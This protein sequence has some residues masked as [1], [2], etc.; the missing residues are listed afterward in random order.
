[1]PGLTDKSRE[2]LQL[3]ANNE[4]RASETTNP[5]LKRIFL[6]LVSGYRELAEHIDDPAQWRAK[7]MASGSKDG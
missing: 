7:L 4:R 5:E 3:A 6:D 1:M 2:Y